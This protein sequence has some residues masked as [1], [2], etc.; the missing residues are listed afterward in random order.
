[1]KTSHGLVVIVLPLMAIFTGIS[2]SA[3]ETV[4][5]KNGQRIDGAVKSVTSTEVLL[6]VAG[7]PLTLP[8]EKVS[9][10]YFGSLLK[11][12]GVAVP[13]GDPINGALEVLKGLQSATTAGVTYRDY[14]PQ[15]AKIQIDRI[16]VSAP[17]GAA[18][19]AILQA[20]EFYVYASNAWNAHIS[21]SNY[22]AIGANPLFEKCLPLRQMVTQLIKGTDTTALGKTAVQGIAI[23]MQGIQPLFS[24]ASA[25]IAEA[26]HLVHPN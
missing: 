11:A 5:L 14:S 7:Q 9:A 16:L 18:K 8:R 6:D 10:I 13:P 2:P 17:D 15:D 3:A 25:K 20:L 19:A 22:A 26:D 4:E 12:T 23:S 24:C 1:M 21:G